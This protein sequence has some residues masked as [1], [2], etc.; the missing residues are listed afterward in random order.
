M[1]QQS[2]PYTLIHPSPQGATGHKSNTIGGGRN[3]MNNSDGI[4][5]TTWADRWHQHPWLTHIGSKLPRATI[6]STWRN[7]YELR[8]YL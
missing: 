5:A 8:L 4:W 3:Y 1:T 7:K 6:R 2:L